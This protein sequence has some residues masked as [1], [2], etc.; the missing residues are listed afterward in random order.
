MTSQRERLRMAWAVALKETIWTWSR[1][2]PGPDK[3]IAIFSTRRSGSTWFMELI[4]ANRGVRY[5]DQPFSL[6]HPAPGHARELPL[7]SHSQF[8]ELDPIERARVHSFLTRLL[9]GDLYVNAPWE[10]WHPTYH[11]RTNRSVLKIVDAKGLIDWIDEVFAPHILYS[12]RHPVPVALSVLRN[13]WPLTAQAYLRSP[14]FVER[15][16]DAQ[17]LD[18]CWR[19]LHEG[20]PLEQ[21][22]LNWGVENLE[23]LRLLGDRPHWTYIAYEDVVAEPERVTRHL[24]DVL[25]L[26]DLDR[27]Q[28]Q[29]RR[30]SR[31]T[32]RLKS[33]AHA[34]PDATERLSAW[35]RH[36]SADELRRAFDVLDRL[37]IDLYR[38]DHPF[39]TRARSVQAVDS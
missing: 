32:R 19:C 33:T 9:A 37:G 11:R 20:T 35:R 5:I 31:S 12:T 21:Q 8:V 1:H 10:P 25:N 34:Q 7:L 15:H 28:A 16:L 23:P 14:S 26:H 24:A 38:P 4:A 2:E 22:V 36:V 30:A 3:D 18:Y 27:M 17:T 13:G 29:V 6:H 39:P